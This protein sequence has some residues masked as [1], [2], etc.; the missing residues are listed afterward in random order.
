MVRASSVSKVFV[1]VPRDYNPRRSGHG[2]GT[3]SGVM[4]LLYLFVVRGD[5]MGRANESKLH[6][7][8]TRKHFDSPLELHPKCE[9]RNRGAPVKTASTCGLARWLC[10]SLGVI[11]F[12]CCPLPPRPAPPP[13]GKPHPTATDKSQDCFLRGG[14]PAPDPLAHYTVA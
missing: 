10:L 6:T 9:C 4:P 14:P 2:L 13:R 1:L 3:C 7:G 8:G 12:E 5:R 11:G